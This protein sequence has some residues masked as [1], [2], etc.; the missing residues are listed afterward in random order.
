MSP[1]PS[2]SPFLPPPRVNTCL[3]HA[4]FLPLP[5]SSSDWNFRLSP[6]SDSIRYVETKRH[7][8]RISPNSVDSVFVSR[9]DF[10]QS[11]LEFAYAAQNERSPLLWRANEVNRVSSLKIFGSMSRPRR[12]VVLEFNLTYFQR[13]VGQQRVQEINGHCAKRTIFLSQPFVETP[14]KNKRLIYFWRCN[15]TF[16]ILLRQTY[17]IAKCKIEFTPSLHL[18][19]SRDK[20]FITDHLSS[21]LTISYKI[22]IS[23]V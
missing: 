5:C 19:Y 7:T 15:E 23:R 8:G 20:D 10:G 6:G 9:L 11:K 21:N 14:G 1:V 13:R 18:P 4:L 3:F 22:F 16:I 12:D 17:F 2:K